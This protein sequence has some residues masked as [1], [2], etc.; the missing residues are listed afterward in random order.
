MPAI[1]L[2]TV[3]LNSAWNPGDRMSFPNLNELSV[4]MDAPVSVRRFANGDDRLIT[5]DGDPDDNPT[6]SMPWSDRTQVRWIED[7]VGELVCYRDDRG[8]KVFGVYLEAEVEEP[9]TTADYGSVSLSLVEV[10][11]SGEV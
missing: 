4:T 2:T 8:R 1:T 9:R 10:T 5:R 11:S 6:M 3:W 7:H